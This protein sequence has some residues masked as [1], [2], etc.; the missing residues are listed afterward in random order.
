MIHTTR[1]WNAHH[2]MYLMAFQQTPTMTRN[3]ILQLNSLGISLTQSSTNRSM[4]MRTMWYIT[5]DHITFP[6]PT[7]TVLVPN[8]L[9]G[10]QSKNTNP[11][12]GRCSMTY[13]L[14]HFVKYITQHQN[15]YIHC[16]TRFTQNLSL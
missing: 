15:Q 5:Y 13:F 1:S 9:L 6:S 12:I 3:N 16:N 10:K 8:S 7:R 2:I 4:M 14:N 11:R